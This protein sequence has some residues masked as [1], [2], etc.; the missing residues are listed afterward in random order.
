MEQK[1][2]GQTQN[3]NWKGFY[4]P[5]GCWHCLI[6]RLDLSKTSI[7]YIPTGAWMMFYKE[8]SICQEA[9]TAS[10]FCLIDFHSWSGQLVAPNTEELSQ[11][12][13]L[14]LQFALLIKV[15]W[16]LCTHLEWWI[17]D[18]QLYKSLWKL[19]KGSYLFVVCHIAVKIFIV[20]NFLLEIHCLC[21]TWF[22]VPITDFGPYPYLVPFTVLWIKISV[23][24]ITSK[25]HFHRL[26]FPTDCCNLGTQA[27]RLKATCLLPKAG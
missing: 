25:A 8:R 27:R 5:E 26:T 15:L 10:N 23:P 4:L 3:E 11:S 24:E 6:F 21:P 9:E 7:K 17:S 13:S 16:F 14:T 2:I 20:C 18:N 12:K 1:T 19:G 22:L